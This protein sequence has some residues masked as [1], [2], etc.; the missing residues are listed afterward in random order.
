VGTPI[1]NPRD[2]LSTII[3]MARGEEGFVDQNGNGV[4][5]TGEPF[6]DLGEPYVDMNDNG[7]YDVG[8]PFWDTN[9][10]GS[11]EG[12][13]GSWDADTVIWAETRV[14][15]TG[16][17]VGGGLP[18]SRWLT[19]WPVP[20]SVGA[21]DVA[22]MDF[23]VSDAN[24]NPLTPTA[25][26]SLTSL[27]NRV[28]LAM[29]LTP[30]NV[31]NLGMGFAQQY[32][33][34]APDPATGAWAPATCTATCTTDPCYRVTMVGPFHDPNGVS[35]TASFTATLAGAETVYLSATVAGVKY[36]P[37]PISGTVDP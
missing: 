30:T 3:V 22:F 5:D 36:G 35:G 8:E 4:Y 19:P 10:D 16:P 26:Y 33:D 21:K 7:K 2:G 6:I 25:T 17:P 11:Y 12:P 20:F 18:F 9:S 23:V 28:T 29:V 27:A 37:I 1:F 15:Y 14:L 32:C 24:L 13:N 31:D 34:V